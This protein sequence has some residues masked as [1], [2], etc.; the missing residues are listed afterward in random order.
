MELNGDKYTEL[1][2]KAASDELEKMEP[3]KKI[4]DYSKYL[5][6]KKNAHIVYEKGYLMLLG[7]NIPGSYLRCFSCSSYLCF[8]VGNGGMVWDRCVVPFDKIRTKKHK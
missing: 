3:L 8:N 5:K 7:R 4:I 1:A 6:T 2:A